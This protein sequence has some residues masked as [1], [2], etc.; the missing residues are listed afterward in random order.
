MSL[1]NLKPIKSPVNELRPEELNFQL[2]QLLLNN[3][4]YLDN[5]HIEN[6]GE[7][8]LI[9]SQISDLFFSKF[10]SDFQNFVAKG[11]SSDLARFLT[12]VETAESEKKHLKDSTVI[13]FDETNHKIEKFINSLNNNKGCYIA[14]MA[15]G[16][17]N[18]PQVMELRKFRDDFLSK[19]IIGRNFIKFYY[20]YSPSLVEKLKN[21]QSINIIIRKGLD[22]FIKAI[23]K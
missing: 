21:K 16:D 5:L 14:T 17:Y 1:K 7:F 22:Q 4:S 23:K 3:Q 15:Y 13:I 2:I 19:T 18:H 6:I 12:M 9:K 11:N 8:N 10:K 20:K